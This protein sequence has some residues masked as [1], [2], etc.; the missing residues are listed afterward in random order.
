MSTEIKICIADGNDRDCHVILT[1]RQSVALAHFLRNATS[2]QIY[3]H[4]PHHGDGN[5][6]GGPSSR[7]VRETQ[8]AIAALSRAFKTAGIEGEEFG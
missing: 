2:M 5:H 7:E 8:F 3:Q 1:P 6:P 4:V